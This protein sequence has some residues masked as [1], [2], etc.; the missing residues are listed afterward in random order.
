MP[1]QGRGA[2]VRAMLPVE[3]EE[4][5]DSAMQHKT[6]VQLTRDYWLVHRNP[7]RTGKSRRFA[8]LCN[9]LLC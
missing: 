8:V 2:V 5:E 4:A 1:K 3:L 7:T 9:S 6:A